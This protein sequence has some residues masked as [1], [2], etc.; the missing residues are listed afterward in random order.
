[1]YVFTYVCA[2]MYAHTEVFAIIIHSSITRHSLSTGGIALCAGE[3]E[4]T[5]L[6][7]LPAYST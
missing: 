6:H 1:M 3:V 2:S 7:C 4:M 5:N